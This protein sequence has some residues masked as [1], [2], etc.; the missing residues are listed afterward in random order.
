MKTKG[1]L[2][3]VSLV[4]DVKTNR[5]LFVLITGDFFAYPGRT[6]YD[7]ESKLKDTNSDFE[8]IKKIILHFFEEKQPEIPGVTPEDFL[9]VIK[10]ALNKVKY[11]HYGIDLEEAN[12]VHTVLKPYEDLKN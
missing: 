1:G 7:L 10:N 9:S 12:S 6:I 5:I 4:V 2:L 11:H 3:R 8:N